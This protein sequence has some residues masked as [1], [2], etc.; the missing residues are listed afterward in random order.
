MAA[1]F[2]Q[3]IEAATRE[4]DERTYRQE[5]Q[6]RFEILTAGRNYFA[7]DRTKNVRQLS[8]DPRLPIFWT[9]D[10]NVNP[11]TSLIGQRDGNQ[12]YCSTSWSCQ[13]RPLGKHG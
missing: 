2:L 10:F 4:L 6:V 13:N 8:F 7:F 12:V 3:E 11:M 1:M 9:L 5:F